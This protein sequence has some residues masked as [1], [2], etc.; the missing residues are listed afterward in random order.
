MS[1]RCLIATEQSDGTFFAIYCH[2]DG[3]VKGGV[4][5]ELFRNYKERSKVE[6]LI[7]QGDRRTLGYEDPQEELYNVAYKKYA[8]LD[9]LKEQLETKDYIYIFNLSDEWIV[10]SEVFADGGGKVLTRKL[11]D[12]L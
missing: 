2:F 1:T 4:G 9:T 10:I 8:N 7:S 5:E 3:Y 12:M 11:A 6:D